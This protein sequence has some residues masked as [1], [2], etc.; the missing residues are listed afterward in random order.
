M[1]IVADQHWLAV[2]VVAEILIWFGLCRLWFSPWA[3]SG[4]TPAESD[5]EARVLSAF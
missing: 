4:G 1:R 3:T 2:I 5:H